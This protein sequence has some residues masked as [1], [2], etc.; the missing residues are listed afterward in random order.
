MPSFSERP[1]SSVYL[2]DAALAQLLR[3]PGGAVVRDLTRRAIR[4]ESAAKRLCPVDHGRLRSSINWRLGRDVRGFY[5]DVG[6]N[7]E[8]AL[9]VEFGTRPH[10]IRP[11]NKR[12]LYW[13]GARSPVAYVNH[14][15]TRAQPFLRPALAY[16][17]S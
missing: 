2:N 9:A 5:A 14:P 17:R 13:K 3:G 1:F 15:G 16:A 8:Y 6:T 11:R 12:A 7:V 10:I 4:V